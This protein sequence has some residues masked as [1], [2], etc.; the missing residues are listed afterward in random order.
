MERKCEILARFSRIILIGIL[1]RIWIRNPDLTDLN[2]LD[3]ISYTLHNKVQADF[4]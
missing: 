3:D 2:P 1:N 4:S